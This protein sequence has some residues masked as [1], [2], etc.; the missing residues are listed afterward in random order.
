MSDTQAQTPSRQ[1]PSLFATRGWRFAMMIV[2]TLLMFVPLVLIS[3]VIEDR[4]S[5]RRAAISE[6]A[7]HWGGSVSLSGPVIV[8]PVQRMRTRTVKDEDGTRRT[9]SYEEAAAPI[10]LRPETLNLTADARSQI[11]R[12]GIFEVPVYAADMEMAFNF[13]FARVEGLVG[14]NETILWT[15]ASLAVFMPATRSF[16]GQAI[17][18]AGGRQFDLEPGTPVE[19]TSGIHAALGDPRGAPEFTLNMG[20]NGANEMSFSPSARQTNITLI[21]DWPHPSFSGDFLPKEREVREDGFSASWEIPHL[22]RDAAQVS[23]GHERAR[24]YFGVRFYNP[25]DIYQKTQRAVKYGILFVALT[26]LSVFLTERLTARPVH[27]AQFVL[28]GISQCVFF[29]LLLSLAEQI[30]FTPSYLAAGSATV[31]LITFYGATGLGLGR[32]WWSLGASL[33]VLYATLYLILR[34]TDY[35]LLAGS[36]LAFIAV[37][38]VMMLTRREDWSAGISSDAQPRQPLPT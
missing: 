26:F 11:R 6:V 29:L 36:L 35:A 3:F 4:V 25:V 22:A 34:S 24:S 32:K 20:L 16:T 19:H 12:R 33:T 31:G 27:A 5:Y 21:S 10:V 30:G 8:L 15:R 14:P 7:Q 28:I 2:L 23:R 37:A 13:D 18:S 9:E 17:L 1:R 38:V